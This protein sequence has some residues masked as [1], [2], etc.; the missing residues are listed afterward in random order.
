MIAL[1]PQD[2]ADQDLADLRRWAVC[3]A[4]VVSAYGGV[5]AGMVPGTR[6]TAERNLPRPS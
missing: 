1:A 6:T 5:A 2:L 4:V 3:T